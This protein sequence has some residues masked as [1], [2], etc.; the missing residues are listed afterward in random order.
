MRQCKGRYF[1]DGKFYEFELGYFH[2][3][4]SD[5]EEFEAA[6]GNFTTAIVDWT[7][8]LTTD[9]GLDLKELDPNER[10]K[11]E[12]EL[13]NLEKYNYV[14]IVCKNELDYNE[15]T[16]N[17]G[18][19]GA[20]VRMGSKKKLKARAVWYHDMKAQIVS[21]ADAGSLDQEEESQEGVE[22]EEG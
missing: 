1:K 16:R 10:K 7:A 12:M 19:D 13:I 15:L 4:G 8:D 5:Y 9:L 3:W 2:Q 17:L 20:I 14:L 21:A 22:D 18:I 11:K 6:P